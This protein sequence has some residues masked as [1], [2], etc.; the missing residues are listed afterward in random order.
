MIKNEKELAKILKCDELCFIS[1]KR[2]SKAFEDEL[3][4]KQCEC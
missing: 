1:S 2:K 3:E 4:D